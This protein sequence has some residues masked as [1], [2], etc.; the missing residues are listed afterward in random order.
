M[1]DE[2]SGLDEARL[3]S[4]LLELLYWLEGEGFGAEATI[5]GMRR[6]VSNGDADVRAALDRLVARGDV[7]VEADV[8]ALTAVGRREAGRQ[9]ADDFADMIKRGHGEC[10]DPSCDCHDNPLGAVACR[11]LT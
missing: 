2:G 4:E 5:A 11:G 7:A 6:F 10:D 9:F 3:Q 1:S 8:Y